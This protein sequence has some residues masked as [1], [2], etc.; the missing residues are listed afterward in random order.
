MVHD[1]T[2]CGQ[3][4]VETA[5]RGELRTYSTLRRAIV[6]ALYAVFGLLFGLPTLLPGPHMCV[7]WIFP[8]GG[9][10]LALR[11]WSVELELED[12]QG[13]CPA[14]EAKLTLPGG[15]LRS[16]GTMNQVCRECR[17][18]LTVRVSLPPAT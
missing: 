9:A 17:A 15:S 12:L 11:A 6:A 10:F 16:D 4:G 14:C 18:K 5:G 7:T 2:F 1:V 3:D 8:V 13:T